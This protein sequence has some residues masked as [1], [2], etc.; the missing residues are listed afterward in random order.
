MKIIIETI[1]HDEQRYDTVG[2]YFI[3]P[4]GDIHVLVS[5]TLSWQYS[6]LVALHELV[7]LL[8]CKDKGIT[9]EAIDEFDLNWKPHSRY[10]EPGNDPKAPYHIQHKFATRIEKLMAKALSVDWKLYNA[11][12]DQ[13]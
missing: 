8:L 12:I 9:N 1:P 3:V 2:D 10:T 11:F 5:G 13:M 6:A 7:E 4:N